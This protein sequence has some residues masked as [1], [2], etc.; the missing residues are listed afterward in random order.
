[1]KKLVFLTLL[2]CSAMAFTVDIQP[3]FI[4]AL[5][6]ESF[7]VEVVIYSDS[8]GYYSLKVEGS[9]VDLVKSY[10]LIPGQSFKV[11]VSVKAPADAGSYSIAA[12]VSFGPET[13]TATATIEVIEEVE[14]SKVVNATL[15]EVRDELV[16]L[17]IRVEAVHDEQ[18]ASRLT[19]AENLLNSANSSYQTGYLVLAQS[20][21]EEAR[22]RMEQ[23][24]TLIEMAEE[25]QWKVNIYLLLIAVSVILI[26]FVLKNYVK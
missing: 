12:Y 4:R 2:L 19:D 7:D 3:N 20:Q 17:K 16:E 21:L 1:M 9:G 11:P 18:A 26:G 13:L 23:A 10:E 6:E 5:P 15:Y 24:K 14:T 25:G 22:I 8:A